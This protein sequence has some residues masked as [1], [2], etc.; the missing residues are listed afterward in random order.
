[1]SVWAIA[2]V[3]DEADVIETVLRHV[4]AQGV[5][6]IIVADNGSTDGTRATLNE[7]QGAL[8]CPLHVHND[9]DVG[10]YQ[11]AK[12]TR[13]ADKAH[14]WG[15]ATWVWPFDA[16]ELWSYGESDR[17]AD[18]IERIGSDSTISVLRSRLWHHFATAVDPIAEEL[19]PFHR[20]HY[21]QGDEAP[22]GKVIVRWQPGAF[23]EAGNHSAFVQGGATR[24]TDIQVR[25][26]PYRSEDQFVRKAING[27][28]AYAATDLP[29][30]TGQHW[31]E[32]GV[33]YQRGGEEALRR[34]YREHF[35][36]DLPSAAGLVY[37]PAR[38]D[39]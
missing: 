36:Y 9:P 15:G 31:R 2:M 23:I 33:H 3:R 5:D 1:M 29:W 26:F 13:L 30:S 8:P 34:I 32:Y 38:I 4:A 6:G 39:G 27:S 37:D 18:Y 14:K 19:S 25:H 20:M 35:F 7:L 11:S 22:L 10:Y 24:H 12:M 16:D 21:R 28:Q 17:L